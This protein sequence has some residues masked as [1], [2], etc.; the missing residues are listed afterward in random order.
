MPHY[1]VGEP[2]SFNVKR[3]LLDGEEVKYVRECDTDEGWLIKMC[4]R[5]DENGRVRPVLKHGRIV[6]LQPG[7]CPADEAFFLEEK[8]TGKVEVEFKG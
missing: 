2:A 4:V 6:M 3:V 8:L 5:I 7:E 1:K